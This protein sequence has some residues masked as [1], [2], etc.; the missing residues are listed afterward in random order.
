MRIRR[1]LPHALASSLLFV[2]LSFPALAGIEVVPAAPARPSI[3]GRATFVA[4]G[5]IASYRGE[6]NPA[7]AAILASW[8][9]SRH[10][11]PVFLSLA[12]PGGDAGAAA[13]IIHA[14]L[15]HGNVRTT[16]LPGDGCA[17]A[18]SMI[19][20]AGE[21]PELP[22]GAALVLHGA[23]CDGPDCAAHGA[24]ATAAVD[25]LQR[26]LMERAAPEILSRADEAGAWG[27]HGQ[28]GALV[29]KKADGTFSVSVLGGGLPQV[30]PPLADIGTGALL[31]SGAQP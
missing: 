9:E 5:D 21:S 31:R 18:C 16:V 30:L 25:R 14:I 7:G 28:S 11:R 12:G 3:D 10:G 27:L 4:M 23:S 8:L 15:S 1:V 20:A 6:V 22:P 26:L 24:Q 29:V 17:S 2:L 19:W 13:W